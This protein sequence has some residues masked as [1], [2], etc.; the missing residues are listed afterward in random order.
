MSEFIN[1]WRGLGTDALAMII[2]LL[3]VIVALLWAER[4]THLKVF[5]RY[6]AIAAYAVAQAIAVLAYHA[7]CRELL[8]V[9]ALVFAGLALRVSVKKNSPG[10]TFVFYWAYLAVVATILLSTHYANPELFG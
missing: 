1:Y 8:V 9:Q 4:K 10:S 5:F 3:V 7:Q 2:A 6:S